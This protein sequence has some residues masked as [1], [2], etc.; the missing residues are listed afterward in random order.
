MGGEWGVLD[1]DAPCVDV[2]R[3]K[4]D[5][6]VQAPLVVFLGKWVGRCPWFPRD[7]VCKEPV[8]RGVLDYRSRKKIETTFP[9]D[10]TNSSDTLSCRHKNHGNEIGDDEVWI[11]GVG[12]D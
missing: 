11:T 2:V 12:N 3:E 7:L 4:D 5:L 8:K 6:P 1:E 10:P 9:Q